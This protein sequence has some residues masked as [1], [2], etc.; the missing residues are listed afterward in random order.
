MAFAVPQIHENALKSFNDAAVRLSTLI[1]EISSGMGSTKAGFAPQF[2]IAHVFDESEVTDPKFVTRDEDGIVTEMSMVTF[3]R[4]VGVMGDACKELLK[5][6]ERICAK[7]ELEPIASQEVVTDLLF[8]WAARRFVGTELP[9]FM[10]CLSAYLQEKVKLHG[11]WIPVAG[12]SVQSPFE[13]GKVQIGPLP[14]KWFDNLCR[15]ADGA[16]ADGKRKAAMVRNIREHQGRLQGSAAVIARVEAEPQRAQELAFDWAAQSLAVLRIYSPGVMSPGAISWVAPYGSHSR[17]EVLS[18]T[19]ED[20]DSFRM[21]SG[22]STPVLPWVVDNS[23]LQQLGQVG[24][25]VLH[26]ILVK[27]NRSRYEEDLLNAV[28][29]YSRCASQID[30]GDKL[31]YAIRALESFLLQSESE[32]IQQTVGDRVAYAI[33]TPGQHRQAIAKNFKKAYALRSRLVHHGKSI[34]DLQELKDFYYNAWRF[35]VQAVLESTKY[36]TVQAFVEE[37]DRRKY[38]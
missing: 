1:Q 21:S 28:L 8:T 24:L 12:L 25:G 9:P 13:I 15:I 10:E 4:R 19:M 3:G 20:D 37:L 35:M 27:K 30:Q 2:K 5:T 6:A 33:G 22:S 38:E 31:L 29:I 16:K 14:E 26:G 11:V 32:P 18:F 7:K 17:Q 34:D 36:S 23:L